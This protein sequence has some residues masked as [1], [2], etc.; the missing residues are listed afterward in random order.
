MAAG[1]SR[2]RAIWLGLAASGALAAAACSGGGVSQEE[3]AGLQERYDEA[4]VENRELNTEVS[5][6]QREVGAAGGETHLVSA[7]P[8]R[9]PRA[10]QR[11]RAKAARPT[12]RTRVSPA[13]THGA[14]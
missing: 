3:H 12:S 5:A 10:T 9:R 8:R 1:V 11:T 4:R 7:A 6:L 2:G 14:R 13:P